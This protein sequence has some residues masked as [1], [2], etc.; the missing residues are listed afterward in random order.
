MLCTGTNIPREQQHDRRHP[1]FRKMDGRWC[2]A[3]GQDSI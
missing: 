2:R 1:I 3:D